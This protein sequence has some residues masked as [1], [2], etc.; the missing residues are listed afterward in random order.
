MINWQSLIF[1]SLWISGLAILLAAFSYHYW[2]AS[3]QGRKLREQLSRPGFLGFFW[4][5]MLLVS[6]GLLGTSQE[7]WE[8]AIWGGMA[9]ITLIALVILVIPSRKTAT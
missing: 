6:L 4:L 1:N 5:A 3:E 7:P 2:A 8:M 9:L